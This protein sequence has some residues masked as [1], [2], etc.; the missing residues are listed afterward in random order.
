MSLTGFARHVVPRLAF[1]A[2][3]LVFLLGLPDALLAAEEISEE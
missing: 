2:T 3:F 1:A